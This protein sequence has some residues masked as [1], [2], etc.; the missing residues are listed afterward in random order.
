MFSRE[1]SIA[2]N[3][4]KLASTAIMKVYATPFEVQH[5]SKEQPVTEADRQ[6]NDIIQKTILTA[7]PDD[8]WL[9]EESIDE[10]KRLNKKRVWIVDPL[11]GTKEFIAKIPEFAISIGLS[12]EGRTVV[13]VILN[14]A[15]GRL[16]TA[17]K[18]KGAFCDGKSIRVSAET[19]L[20]QARILSSR[21][22]TSRGEWTNYQGKFV[23]QESGGMAHKMSVVAEGNAEGSFSLQPKS[24]WDLCA[25]LVLIEE[26][27]GKVTHLDGSPFLFNKQNPHEPDIV[28]GNRA[29]YQKLIKF[30]L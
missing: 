27:G 14:P 3:A 29:I 1:L 7:F 18:G 20:T 6:A 17:E 26:A 28:Y 24:E 9:S 21:S 8:G 16:F 10:A 12:V 25:G 30:L 22:E 11:D 4:A 13:G 23:I 19:N 2:I 15:T 5:K